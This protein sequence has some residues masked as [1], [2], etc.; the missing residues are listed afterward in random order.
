V[1]ELTLPSIADFGAAAFDPG[2]YVRVPDEWWVAVADV[3]ASTQLAAQGRDRD[4]NFVAGAVVAALSATCG[5]PEQPAACQFGG[6]GA[7]ALVPPQRVDEANRALATLAYWAE[8]EIQVP[9]RTGM[10]PVAELSQAGHDVLAALYDF[11]KGNVF[12]LF[13]GDGVPMAE[14]WVKADAR[15]RVAPAEGEVPGLEGLSCRWRPVPPRH[16]QVLCAIIDPSRPG[17]EGLAALA[18]LQEQIERVV[19]TGSAAPLGDGS[20]LTLGFVPDTH[21]L[22]VEARTEPRHRR[23]RR[24]LRAVVGTA[25]LGLVHRA[26]GRLAGVDSDHYRHTLAERT[27]YRKQAGGPR[28]VLDVTPEEADRIEAL[29]AEAEDRGDILFGTARSSATT[30]T[31]MVGDFMADRHVHF[32]DGDGLGFWRASTV[33]KGKRR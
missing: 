13:L 21:A 32:V 20:H 3:V 18:R 25:I 5:R 16:G 27:D 4:V 23:W 31:C 30:L 1:S 29:L 26:G 10:V 9:L 33:L 22:A 12:G 8:Q 2:R 7:V 24:I 28:F 17:A 11:G 19:P 15:W 14:L 6:D